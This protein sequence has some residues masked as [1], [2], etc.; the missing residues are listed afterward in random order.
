MRVD[1]SIFIRNNNFGRKNR[2]FVHFSNYPPVSPQNNKKTELCHKTQPYFSLMYRYLF[3][4][5]ASLTDDA[6]VFGADSRG[7][8]NDSKDLRRFRSLKLIRTYDDAD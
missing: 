5:D 3:R 6:H 4:P 7:V 8:V 2:I 1:V